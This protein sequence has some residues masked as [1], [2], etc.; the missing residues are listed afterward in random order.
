MAEDADQGDKTEEPSE[1]RLEESRRKGD[2]ASSREFNNVLILSGTLIVLI[3]S[4]VFMYETLT[5]YIEWIYT[6]DAKNM[7]TESSLK[8]ILTRSMATAGKCIAP[9]FATALCLGVFSQVTQ[10]GFLFAPDVLELKFDRLNPISGFQRLFSKK[11]LVEALKGILKFTII[12]SVSYGMLKNDFFSV[13]GLLTTELPQAMSFGQAMVLKL[14][15]AIMIGLAVIGGLDF[16]WEKYTYKQ[17]MMMTKD[18]AKREAK[19]KDG[20]PEVKNKIR[21]I[22]REM[23]R[24]RMM[25]AV[26]TADVIITNPTH[27]SIAIKY[28]VNNMVAPAV[29]AKGADHI[30]MKIRELAKEND[31]PIVENVPLA[32]TLYKTVKIGQGVP[33]TL[34]KAVAEIIG[35]VYKLKKKRKAVSSK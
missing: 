25:D 17:K 20:N 18:E 35:F 21:A 13:G 31:V 16:A 29:V 33:R 28:D 7:Y 27:I 1:Y 19:E 10:I 2:V 3:L 34:Y 30:A 24:K 14:V 4:S 12:L 11:S 22:Q 23:S 9:I 8:M 5:E 15:I 26:K 6:L 32:R